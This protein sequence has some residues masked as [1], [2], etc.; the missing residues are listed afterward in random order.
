M[1]N[2]NFICLQTVHL[3]NQD[4]IFVKKERKIVQNWPLEAY[5]APTTKLPL[6]PLFPEKSIPLEQNDAKK[7][8]TIVLGVRRA[9]EQKTKANLLRAFKGKIFR[10]HAFSYLSLVRTAA[11]SI[12]RNTVAQNTKAKNS[13]FS[14][15]VFEIFLQR[16]IFLVG[17][18]E[19]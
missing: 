12:I 3:E 8:G 14:C 13:I 9:R 15:F 5:L 11:P 2:C 6:P 1:S 10:S 19:F 7:V 16:Q 17:L 4:R 18:R